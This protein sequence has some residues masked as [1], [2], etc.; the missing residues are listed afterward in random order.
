[1][2]KMFVTRKNSLTSLLWMV[3]EK[4]CEANIFGMKVAFKWKHMVL[5][6]H[7]VERHLFNFPRQN[8]FPR[9]MKNRY[10]NL[11]IEKTDTNI[12]EKNF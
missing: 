10:I 6:K 11:K 8:N 3:I 12:S 9:Q 2:V 5:K 1:M 7:Q 4:I